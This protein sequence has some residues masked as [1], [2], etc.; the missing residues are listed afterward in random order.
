MAKSKRLQNA[1]TALQR[2]TGIKLSLND[3]WFVFEYT[4]DYNH[5]R[6][7]EAIGLHPDNG[8]E[9]LNKPHIAE[10]IRHV[11]NAQM[12]ASDVTPEVV[13]EEMYQLY[14]I[15]MQKGMLSVASKQL[16]QLARHSHI[17]AYAAQRVAVAADAQVA[18]ALAKGRKRISER[19]TPTQAEP[20]E[21]YDFS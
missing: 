14:L 21:G 9:L 15:A 17:D 8:N 20:S 13:K 4:K 2:T 12:Q 16:D 7:A 6:A 1:V 3:E 5:R 11:Y 18:E 19:D 10:A